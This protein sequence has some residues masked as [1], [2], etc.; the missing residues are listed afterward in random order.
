MNGFSVEKVYF[1]LPKFKG[2]LGER[3]HVVWNALPIIRKEWLSMAYW[4]IAIKHTK[5]Q[6]PNLGN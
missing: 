3:I 4:I 2:K 6:E 1:H 5:P